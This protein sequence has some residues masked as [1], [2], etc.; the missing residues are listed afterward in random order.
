VDLN[1]APV[2]PAAATP[3]AIALQDGLG[4]SMGLDFLWPK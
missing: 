2:N 3:G 1:Q 4:N